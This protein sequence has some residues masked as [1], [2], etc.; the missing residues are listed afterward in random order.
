MSDSRIGVGLA[1]EDQLL[2]Q[3]CRLEITP[4][5]ARRTAEL[6]AS[7]PDWPYLLEASIRHAVGPLL[8]HG[9]DDIA[10]VIDITDKVPNAFLRNLEELYEG[11]AR[12]NARLFDALGEVVEKLRN[13]GVEV[14]GLKDVQ[15]A[16]G[17]YGDAALRPMGDIDLLVRREDWDKAV[18]VLPT[19]GFLPRP[20]NDVP[21]TRKY[22]MAQHFRRAAD[23]IWI[24]LQWNVLQREWDLYAEGS[25]T[26]DA[27]DM[28]RDPSTIEG[29]D[30]ELKAPAL[31]DMLFHL[32][33]HLEGHRYS[34]LV[35]FCDIA[36]L[37]RRKSAEI[38]W[39]A[40]LE[41]G[42]R[43]GA[44]S[45]LYYVL[46]LVERLLDA[47]VPSEIL[48]SLAP[49]FFH[50]A[51]NDPLFGNLTSLHLALD[52]IRLAAAPPTGVLDAYERIVRRQAAR[53]MRMDAEL[54]RFITAFLGRSGALAIWKGRRPQ[55]RFPDAELTSFEPIRLL[56]LK[57][58]RLILEQALADTGFSATEEGRVAK[59]IRLASR[60]PVLAGDQ[61]SLTLEAV[62]SSKLPPLIDPAEDLDTNAASALRSLRAHL[63]A[64]GRDDMHELVHLEI[65][66]L[67]AEE[68]VVAIA[69]DVGAGQEDR[70]F[71]CCSLI[72]LLGKLPEQL[73]WRLVRELAANYG[74]AD[75][76]WAGLAVAGVIT[77]RAR[78]SDLDT[79]APRVFE[80]AR[81]GPESVSRY[82]WLRAAYYFALSFAGTEGVKQ[83]LAY[84][85]RALLPGRRGG[86]VIS[87]I[88]W[89][90]VKGVTGSIARRPPSIRDFAYWLE[91]ATLERLSDQSEPSRSPTGDAA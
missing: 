2:L 79:G 72:D 74:V 73:D 49:T 11:S 80:W 8:K 3:A 14:L 32:C 20:G 82:P 24:D 56:V 21:Y 41:L 4:D 39:D 62:W 28:W 44:E 19:L 88:A 83:K 58:N 50:G 6:I 76:V 63:A 15:L 17:V 51:L 65:Y 26:Y 70:L 29:L 42:R 22:A 52:E 91:P 48:D 37:L 35:L 61:P 13:V 87:R 57:Q 66:P 43:Y 10:R 77:D 1:V 23:E 55:R 89:D 9:F 90:A 27:R 68:L 30:F 5:G 40:F 47:P 64:D 86:S 67:R 25:F 54:G 12:R 69:A 81:Y 60:D 75:R 71:R 84:L 46:L 36:E 7:G 18:S 33:L 31:E 38:R 16:V 53:A 85:G 59:T 78:G 34:E 45:S